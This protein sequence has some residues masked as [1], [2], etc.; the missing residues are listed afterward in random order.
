M[1][2]NFLTVTFDLVYLRFGENVQKAYLC[3]EV[4]AISWILEPF[5]KVCGDVPEY[6]SARKRCSKNDVAKSYREKIVLKTLQLG[7]SV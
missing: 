5:G 6:F 3:T 7:F 1:Q 2:C 4:T